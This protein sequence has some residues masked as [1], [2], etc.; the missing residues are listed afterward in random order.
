MLNINKDPSLQRDETP[1]FPNKCPIYDIK[2]SDDEASV[3]LEIGGMR[4]TPSLLSL[5]G[6]LQFGHE[7]L[8]RVLCTDQIELIGIKT[9]QTNHLC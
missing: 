5:P 3:M 1:H 4:S 2:Q 6:P 7:A 9:V 8:D